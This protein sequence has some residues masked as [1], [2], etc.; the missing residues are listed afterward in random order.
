VLLA[1]LLIQ[2]ETVQNFV[3][4]RVTKNLSK[5]L[6]TKV[7]IGH[8]S[9]TLFNKMNFED[10]LILDR[11]N[12]TLLSAG[13]MAVRITDWFFLKDNIE[14]KYIGLED[15]VIKMD[16]KDSVWNYQFILDH[17]AS[18]TSSAKKKKNSVVIDFKKLDLKNVSFVKN[19]LW[20]GQRL[21]IGVGSLLMDIQKFDIQQNRFIINEIEVDK[22]SYASYDLEGFRP[23]RIKKRW[24]RS[25]GFYFNEGNI[26][27]EVHSIQITNGSFLDEKL[28]GRKPLS[29]FDGNYISF[30]KLKGQITDLV[31]AADTIKAKIDL[32]ANE[33][34]GLEVKK[35]AADFRL[36][37]ERMEFAKLKLRT[38]KSYLS[39]Y[40]A[41]NYSDFNRDMNDYIEKVV[42]H[43]HFRNSEV[44][45]DDI[46]YFAPELKTWN[47]QFAISGKFNGT[48]DDFYV[49][50]IFL[51]SGN[52]SYVAGDLRMKGLPD[53][54]RTTIDLQNGLV[55]TNFDELAVIVPE[56]KT[57]KSPDL[58]ALGVSRFQGNFRG[59]IRNFITK[60]SLRTE[61]G[62]INADIA[63]RLPSNSDASYNGRITTKQF[64]LGRFIRESTVGR[65]TFNGNV[66]GSSFALARMRMKL[67]GQVDEF[68]YKD[69]NYTALKVNGTFQKKYFTGELKSDDPNFNLTAGIEIDVTGDVPRF[70][71]LG[72]LVRSDL[73]KLNFTKDNYQLTGFFDLNFSGNNIDEF[74]GTAKVLNASLTKDS[75][76]IDFDSLTVTA[77]N[78]DNAK[79]LSVRSNQ[80]DADLRGKFRI[81]NLPNA[82]ESFLSRYYPSLIAA[83]TG[84]SSQ[85][86][87]TFNVKTRNF[88]PYLKLIDPRLSGFDNATVSGSVNTI[89]SG[90]NI[91]ANVPSFSYEKYRFSNINLTGV[92]NLNALD[93][94]ARIA[95]VQV[96]DSLHFPNSE[97]SIRSE[98]DHSSVHLATRA[99]NTLNEANLNADVFTFKDGVRI[100]FQPSSFVINDKRWNLE[101][102]G[103]LVISR[104][105]V[106]AQNVK[107]VQGL[108]EIIVETSEEEGAN[109]N[110]LVVRLK[111]LN[112]GDFSPLIT[113]QPRMEGV[114]SGEVS[115]R[116]FYNRFSMDANI[117]AEQF[118]LDDD[119]VGV[120]K[121]TGGFDKQT[122]L[123]NYKVISA[124]ENF[125]FTAD[126]IFHTKDSLSA[127]LY[128]KVK[129]NDTKINFLNQFLNV[130]FTDVQGKASGEIILK[131]NPKAPT[132]L[133]KVKLREG[134]L[135]VN[136]TQVKYFI[137]DADIEFREGVIDFGNMVV[138]DRNNNRGTIKGLLYQKGFR[139]MRYDFSMNADKLLVLDTKRRDNE[140]FYGQAIGAVNMTLQGPED[141]L[142]MN[143]IG[144]VNDTTHIYIPPTNTRES[145]EADFIIFKQYGKEI[146][147]T[148]KKGRTNLTVDLDLIANNRAQIDVIL[149]DLAGDVI[150]ATGNG[151][152]RMN[153]VNGDVAINGRYTI[154]SGRY[155]FNFQSIFTKPFD[156]KG[157]ENNYIE[158]TGD[159]SNARI[160]VE[161][162]YT[163]ERVSLSNLFNNQVQFTQNSKG[164][165]NAY[166]GDV[167]VVAKLS[168]PL[169]APKIDF[170]LDFP[171]NT[172]LLNDNTFAQFLNKM[173][174]D[175]SE[176][177]KQV[178][179][180]I[181]FGSFAPYGE[182]APKLDVR[183]VG[184]NTISQKITNEINKVF[185]NLLFKL[186]GDKSLQFDV[187]TTTYSSSSIFNT[188]TTNNFDRQRVNLN[189]NKNLFNDKVILTFGGDLDFNIASGVSRTGN[190]QWLPDFNAQIMLSKDKKIRAIVFQ[191]S[192]LD[193]AGQGIGR[194][195][196]MGVSLSYSKD[197]EKLFGKKE[198]A[199]E[200]KPP[201]LPEGPK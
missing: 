130:V 83:P 114:A 122:G 163:A 97:I 192:S 17:F 50:D 137:D 62:I 10:M 60:G 102:E 127:P 117:T 5:E 80:F 133:G 51:R 47:K 106:S 33:R 135:L 101:K 61:L 200:V 87:F 161:A 187:S 44:H 15:A 3:V 183:S 72:D 125:D 12:D 123:V 90:F 146:S 58:R 182:L 39:D 201:V 184:L 175:E 119:S 108:Q 34:S 85:E 190:F 180:L 186:T 165:L 24:K 110:N 177:L 88:N 193:V 197:F 29:H 152:I 79:A 154:E 173:Q 6:K 179:Y 36:T 18:P 28:G 41:M 105:F 26:Y 9:F 181:V 40:Y 178:T 98:N 64:N 11:K 56:I 104:N 1:W 76:K 134:S 23:L 138:R 103:E 78:E 31:F 150:K 63:M 145:A 116:D 142:R 22:P 81:M 65:I 199:P 54:D 82:F 94:K 185:S 112:I 128:T 176:M 158:W 13:K 91:T 93:L 77:F 48:V 195:N 157:G 191:K 151:R 86:N 167:Y 19:D 45:S 164:F 124:N 141:D 120:V 68:Q 156:L 84:P 69:Y 95:D 92:G 131:G 107:F 160:N 4:K 53:V 38:N 132:L 21:V 96:T 109:A 155:D 37:P 32:S 196:R 166:R 126:G 2:T 189:L 59:T 111:N 57:L 66:E 113:T 70:N 143:I 74:L 25:D 43:A 49:G 168:G 170:R 8:V 188:T 89:D 198:K 194:R 73:K 100:N 14:L 55:Q 147:E 30:S 172:Q 99:N 148:V 75:V 71:V 52:V 20:V 42:M 144:E 174:Q 139:D 27:A 171:P 159:P 7:S 140:S 136:Y 129:L 121:I 115:L 149:D 16:R 153:I 118:R 162:Q 67:N 46:A 169:G 35:I